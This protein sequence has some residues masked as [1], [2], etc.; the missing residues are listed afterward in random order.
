MR[1]DLRQ[2]VT[3]FY[4]LVFL[5]ELF[6]SMF[7]GI[8]VLFMLNDLGLA[9][10]QVGVVK[11]FNPLTMA[12][13][14]IPTGYIGDKFG[15]RFNFIL[16]CL[17]CSIGFFIYAASSNVYHAILGE[18][19]YSLGLAFQTGSLDAMLIS[20]VKEQNPDSNMKITIPEV[21]SSAQ[22]YRNIG[23]MIGGTLGIMLSFKSMYLPWLAGGLGFPFVALLALLMDKHTT[24]DNE[25]L[26][27]RDIFSNFK[28]YFDKKEILWLT[29]LGVGITAINV[30]F[31][32]YWQVFMEQDMGIKIRSFSF[33]VL[34]ITYNIFMALGS[35]SLKFFNRMLGENTTLAF[36]AVVTAV[37]T[38]TMVLF[39]TP[40]LAISSF[41]IG[42]FTR[43]LYFP[44]H[45]HVFSKYIPDALRSLYMSKLSFFMRGFT[46]ISYLISIAIARWNPEANANIYIMSVIGLGF[47]SISVF[48]LDKKRYI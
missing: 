7:Y 9:M 32:N 48:F 23:L 4:A 17:C 26:K 15:R 3:L 30:P 21:L 5:F 31:F 10:Y 33:V 14:E 22:A 2:N 28:S 34:Y 25:R 19:V 46:V 6:R 35:K 24:Y 16:S 43:G 47:I 44:S 29:I 40:A 41:L 37:T 39:T 1:N 8:G 18:I 42:E 11:A 36:S 27:I 45:T 38:L 20:Q 13:F 12:I